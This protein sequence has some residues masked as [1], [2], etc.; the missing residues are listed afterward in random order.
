[1]TDGL[2]KSESGAQ[3]IARLEGRS[4]LKTLEPCLFAE[5]G[6]PIYGDVVEF[7]GPE[8]TGKTEMLYHLIARCI[9]PKSVGGLEVGVL[10]IDTDFHFD[11]LRLVTILEYRLSSQGTEATIKLYLERFFLINC[12]SSSQLLLTLYSLENMFFSHPSL[13]LLIIDS[14]SAFYWI[15]RASGGESLS[16]QEANLKRCVQF[17]KKLVK[18]HRLVLFATTQSLMKKSLSFLESS[19]K[20]DHDADPDYRP[21]LCKSWQQLITHRIFFSKQSHPDGTK[22]FSVTACHIQNNHIVKRPFSIT[23]HGIQF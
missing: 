17:L 4:S 15:D 21:F 1:M 3:L 20:S 10:F 23:E 9:L 13:S 5:E 2:A 14:I 8:G 7:H 11:M 12:H 6:Y 18:E 19:E 16:L 22:A